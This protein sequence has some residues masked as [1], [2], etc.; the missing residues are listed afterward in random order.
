MNINPFDLLK[1][2][3]AIQEQMGSFQEKLGKLKVCGSAGGGMAEVDMNGKLE[4]LEIRLAKEAVDPEEIGL[5]Q[6]LIKAAFT[7]AS[8]KVHEAIRQ[9]MSSMTGGMAIPPGMMGF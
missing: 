8:E 1:N 6:D 7:D 2:A 4:V 5:L 9:E 3:Q